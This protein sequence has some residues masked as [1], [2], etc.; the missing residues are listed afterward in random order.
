MTLFKKPKKKQH[1]TAVKVEY[2][3]IK[4]KSK[5]EL[6]MY[7]MLEM[8]KFDFGYE[9]E[10]FPIIPE[11]EYQGKLHPAA[12][13]T[14]DFIVTF[15]DLIVIIETKGRKNEAW[16]LR[17]KLF[18]KWLSEVKGN[19]KEIVFVIPRNKLNCDEVISALLDYRDKKQPFN[20]NLT[21]NKSRSN[22]KRKAPTMFNN[23]VSRR[24]DRG[25]L[26]R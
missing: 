9:T 21:D 3:G 6:Y 16:P 26:G 22:R 5:L 19:T 10:K 23:K 14:P 11:F 24:S 2:K 1:S 12:I 4:F 15:P 18:K 8:M 7:K 17:E 25:T 20:V 13:Y